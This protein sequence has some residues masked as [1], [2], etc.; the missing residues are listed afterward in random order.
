M[1]IKLGK[2]PNTTSVR[3]A[4]VIPEDLKQQLERYA[5]FYSATWNQPVDTAQ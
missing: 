1:K 3:M 2:L 4:A 5:K